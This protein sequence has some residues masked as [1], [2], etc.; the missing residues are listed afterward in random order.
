MPLV[1]SIDGITYQ[2]SGIFINVAP[3]TYTVYV[4]DAANC[5]ATQTVTISTSGTG[6]GIQHLLL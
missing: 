5:I 1:Y 6:P 2:T 3:A 4:K